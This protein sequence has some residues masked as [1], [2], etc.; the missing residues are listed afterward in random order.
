MSHFSCTIVWPCILLSALRYP[1]VARRGAEAPRISTILSLHGHI[2]NYLCHTPGVLPCGRAFFFL[3]FDTL[4]LRAEAL[5]HQGFQPFCHCMATSSIICV[6]LQGYYRVA[7]L[8]SALR[9][10]PVARR[11]AEA[12]CS[13]PIRECLAYMVCTPCTSI[14]AQFHAIIRTTIAHLQGGA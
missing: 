2:L 9:Y 12:P 1:P 5:R 13:L 8:L 4:Q 7:V 11:G 14:V 6:T 3:H 10:P